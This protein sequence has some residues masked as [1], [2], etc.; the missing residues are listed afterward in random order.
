MSPEL[1][2]SASVDHRADLWALGVVAYRTLTGRLPF[3]GETFGAI[4]ITINEAEFEPPSA[5]VEGLDPAVDA[6]FRLALCRNIQGRFQTAVEM[7]DALREATKHLA[8]GEHAPGA[9][10][11]PPTARTPSSS[12]D[13]TRSLEHHPAMAKTVTPAEAG[14]LPDDAKRNADVVSSDSPTVRAAT[15]PEDSLDDTRTSA[16]Q[17]RRESQPV[18]S[19]RASTLGGASGSGE[20]PRRRWPLAWLAAALV[21][22]TV[23]AI[24]A[25]MDGGSFSGHAGEEAPGS[26]PETTRSPVPTTEPAA[27]RSEAQAEGG[28]PATSASGL[29]SPAPKTG[30]AAQPPPVPRPSAAP[31]V[32]TTRNNCNP[33]FTV[34]ANGDYVPKPECF[35]R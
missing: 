14:L 12:D 10:D 9:D 22:G 15:G 24:A 19:E 16:D 18:Q 25:T 4:A 34:D 6:W 32:P 23:V 13:A 26:E 28:A 33:P 3:R 29:A 31:K 5:L 1:V 35:P 7:A 17:R 30:P 11:L 21:A 8:S 20:Q 27:A 2:K